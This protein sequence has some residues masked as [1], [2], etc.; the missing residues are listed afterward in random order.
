[1]VLL[2]SCKKDKPIDNTNFDTELSKG[3]YICN[4]GNFM[5]GNSQLSLYNKSNDSLIQNLFEVKNSSK[6]GDVFQPMCFFINN[7]YLI[8]NNSQKIIIQSLS[9]KR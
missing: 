1:M 4:E 8:I 6:L 3:V 2:F 9:I 5:F 7:A